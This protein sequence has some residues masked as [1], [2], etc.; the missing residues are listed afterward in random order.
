MRTHFVSATIYYFMH[1][2]LRQQ[3]NP[4][5]FKKMGNPRTS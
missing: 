5:G 3:P 4:N 2:E 1:H